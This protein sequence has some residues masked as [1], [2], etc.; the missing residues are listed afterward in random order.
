MLSDDPIKAAVQ[1]NRDPRIRAAACYNQKALGSAAT[2][3]INLFILDSEAS[4]RLDL[5][6][7][8]GAASY[9]AVAAVAPRQKPLQKE[10]ERER[11]KERERPQKKEQRRRPAPEPDEGEAD[12]EPGARESGLKG[13]IWDLFGIEE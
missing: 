13:R 9:T 6:V 3:S 1:A 5:S 2:E 10:V 12:V 11:E 8:T 4:E 7:I